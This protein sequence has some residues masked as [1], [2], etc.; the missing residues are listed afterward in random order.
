M[1]E[2]PWPLPEG[3]KW[4]PFGAVAQVASDLVDPTSHP[5]SPHVAPNHI[6]AESGKLLPFRTIADDRVTSAKHRFHA[7]QV[8][9]SKIRP[10][11]AKV[12]VAEFDGLCSADMYPIDTDL[13]PR[14]L[15][16]W[17]LTRE[18][19][20]QAAGQQARTVLPKINKKSLETLPVPVSPEPEQCRIVE[21]LEDH[22]SRL[23]A[24]IEIL[25]A[26][27]SR[28]RPL[29]SAFLQQ[30]VPAG[31]VN[32]WR[33]STVGEAGQVQLGRQR[34]PDWHTGPEM[35][36]YLRVANVF[37]DRVDTRDLMEM[38]FSGVFER[39][40][41]TPGD[42]LLNEGQSPEFLGRPA[43][44]RGAPPEVA[45]TNSLI[46]F[47][48]NSDVLPEWALLVFR[49]HMHA[50]RFMKES[51]ITTNIAH[52]SASRLKSVEFPVP[53]LGEQRALVDLA[54]ALLS[55]IE[56]FRV[57]LARHRKQERVLRRSLLHAAFSGRLTRRSADHCV[58][59]E[60]S[61]V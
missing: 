38:D 37:E 24:A 9:Y 27:A 47:K 19:T 56:R 53:P 58:I 5:K 11:L 14:Y 50:G 60:H 12:I 61:R 54:S 10:Y 4:A 33:L 26:V 20:R 59:E 48:A 44:Y 23:D 30:I 2:H 34:H 31:E 45:F 51:R 55:G 13:D 41:L 25:S 39:Y 21:I 28:L 3:W 40:R 16:W 43:I 1:M 18:F 52:L 7:G 32:G 42:V 6:E 29:V 36:P 15:K 35:K 8:L 22:L 46:R 49:R 17:M 57:E